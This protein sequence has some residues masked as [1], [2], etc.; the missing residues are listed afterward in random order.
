M[1]RE[2]RKS[3][4]ATELLVS[5]IE[6][7]IVTW[8]R[9]AV[10][11]DPDAFSST[12]DPIFAKPIGTGEAIIEVSRTALQMVWSISDDA[13]ARYVVHC[14][15]RYHNIVSFSKLIPTSLFFGFI[16]NV[17]YRQRYDRLT[18][19]LSFATKRGP[20]RLPSSSGP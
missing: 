1:R 19:D 8:L 6:H 11:M 2:L 9:D 10:W 17:T 7:E 18:P 12:V 4:P 16:L 3:G 5:E 15:A 14:C 20:P 13:F